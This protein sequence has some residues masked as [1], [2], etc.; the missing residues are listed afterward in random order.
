MLRSVG[1]RATMLGTSIPTES[2]VKAV[3]YLRPKLF[4]VSISH[5]ADE[6]TLVADFAR[7]S[8]ACQS[9]ETA[10]VVGGRALNDAVRPQLAY[11]AYCDTLQQLELFAATMLR[12]AHPRRRKRPKAGHRPRR[13]GR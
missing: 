5:I 13:G 8:A 12:E 1:I 9:T 7:L 4:F 11:S 3:H 10:L 2:L 6:A